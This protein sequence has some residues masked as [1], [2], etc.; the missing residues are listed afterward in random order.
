MSPTERELNWP[1]A[2]TSLSER[3]RA[4]A[5]PSCRVITSVGST[6]GDSVGEGF[7]V[8]DGIGVL[9]GNGVTDGIGVELVASENV[10]VRTGVE[11][12]TTIG[13]EG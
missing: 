1:P 3:R 9:G 8:G 5:F 6:T 12:L 7:A 11:S 2:K 10:A 13:S 4:T